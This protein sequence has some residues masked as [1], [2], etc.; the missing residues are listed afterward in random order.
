VNQ[1][2]QVKNLSAGY[3]K[4]PVL[5]DVS[6]HVDEGEVVAVIG[7]NGAGK[8]TLL[9]T[10]SGLIKPSA[11]QIVFEGQGIQGMSP[12]DVAKAGISHIPE[13]RR[14]FDNMTVMENLLMGAY[15]KRDNLK[16]GVLDE[17]FAMFPILKERE[18]QKAK[19]L[20]GGQ[21]QMLAVGRGLVSKP[22]I[23][24]L[25]EPS[26]GLAPIL[27][28]ATYDKLRTLKERGL[29]VLLIEQNVNYALEFASRAYVLEN[30]RIVME[31]SSSELASSEHI[32]QHYLGLTSG[33][34]N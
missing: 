6:F 24:M 25:D 13:G 27:V 10:I 15:A 14:L 5:R 17:V 23:L 1:T 18:K 3:G 30:G 20:S 28:D 9:K 29:T 32:K 33:G 7:P 26:L 8:T 21:K 31:G 4:I 34:D 12:H 2:L 19:D 16:Q 22:A 11:G